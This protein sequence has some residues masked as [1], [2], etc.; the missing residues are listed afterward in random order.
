MTL[1][2]TEPMALETS[3]HAAQYRR[4]TKVRL[5]EAHGGKCKDCGNSYAPYQMEFD[6]RDPQ[7]KS[8]NVSTGG[9]TGYD[10]LYEES[11][12]CDLVCV[13]CHK[14]RTHIQRCDGCVYCI[15]NWEGD[16]YG[17]HIPPEAKYCECG[18]RIKQQVKKCSAC[19]KPGT[20]I[21]WPPMEE[22]LQEIES[23]SVAAT[24]RKLGVS[25]NAVKKHVQKNIS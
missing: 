23:S 14:Q 15:P 21:D 7:A 16:P 18:K 20:K 17:G 3:K 19:Y 22:L 25:H 6:H 11:L 10:K 5:I 2:Y 1:C 8:F 9:T 12:K 24:A 4:R 13:L